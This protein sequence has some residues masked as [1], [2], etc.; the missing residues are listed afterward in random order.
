MH[1]R[2]REDAGLLED[3][4]FAAEKAVEIL[5][6]GGKIMFCGNGGSASDAQHIAAELTGR[7]YKNR[8]ALDAIALGTNTPELTAISNDYGYDSVFSRQLEAHGRPGDM[9]I[10]LTTSGQSPN[11]LKALRMARSLN[12][13][14]VLMTGI[15]GGPMKDQVDVLIRIPDRDTPRIQEGHILIG[16]ILCQLIEERIFGNELG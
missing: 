12:I 8:P 5:R 9:F 15:D 6:K 10:G 11:V 2:L 1:L 13:T 14:T 4:T 7:Y 3:I 16:H